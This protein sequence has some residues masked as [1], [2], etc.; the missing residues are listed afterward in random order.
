MGESAS[1]LLVESVTTALRS[2]KPEVWSARADMVLS[3]DARQALQVCDKPILYLQAAED[4]FVAS[5]ALDEIR[6]L[7]PSV[8]VVT[9]PGPHLVLQSRPREAAEAIKSF[10]N[11]LPSF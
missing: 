6:R 8:K 1:D 7:K 2:L 9:I 4:Q 10:L 11:D 5:S 3:A